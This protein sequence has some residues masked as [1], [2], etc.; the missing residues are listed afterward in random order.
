MV[1]VQY[2]AIAPNCQSEFA[3]AELDRALR[4]EL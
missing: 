4:G 2:R 1:S 3:N